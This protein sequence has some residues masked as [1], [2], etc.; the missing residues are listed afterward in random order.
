MPEVEIQMS[1]AHLLFDQPV[2]SIVR[3]MNRT[4]RTKL[5]AADERQAAQEIFERANRWQSPQTAPYP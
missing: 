2:Y 3:S 5:A 1:A 4:V